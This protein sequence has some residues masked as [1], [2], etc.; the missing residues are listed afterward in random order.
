VTAIR[1]HFAVLPVTLLAGATIAQIL[2]GI[3]TV[4]TVVET[5]IALLHQLLAV[6]ML[7]FVITCLYGRMGSV[8]KTRA[9]YD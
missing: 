7:I 3:L 6:V 8:P 2:L 1:Y 4:V 9:A 5:R